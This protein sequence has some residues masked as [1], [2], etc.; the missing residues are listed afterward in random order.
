MMEPEMFNERDIATGWRWSAG[1][2]PARST[3]SLQAAPW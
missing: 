3:R 1:S 2:M